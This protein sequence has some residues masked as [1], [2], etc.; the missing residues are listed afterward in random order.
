[1][2]FNNVQIKSPA[3]GIHRRSSAARQSSAPCAHNAIKN[4]RADRRHNEELILLITHYFFDSLST[5][6][7]QLTLAMR[8]LP[9]VPESAALPAPD[10]YSMNSLSTHRH[11]AVASAPALC[12]H[13]DNQTSA[14]GSS[15]CRWTMGSMGYRSHGRVRALTTSGRLSGFGR[16]PECC[17]EPDSGWQG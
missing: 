3:P 9:F 13:N 10:A 15:D 2:T 16:K 12:P 7:S 17:Q 6:L 4:A 1:M 5:S 8:F 14:V 11:R